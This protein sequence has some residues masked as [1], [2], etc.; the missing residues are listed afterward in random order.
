MLVVNSSGK[1][2]LG[3]RLGKPGHWQFPQGGV[4][5]GESLRKN[6]LR[7]LREEIGIRRKHIASIKKLAAKNW[8]LWK[9]VPAY[10]KGRW[11]GQT[12]TFWLIEFVGSDQ[13]IDLQ[14]SAEPEFKRWRWC[15]LSQVRKLAA[16]ERIKGY[17]AALSEVAV[18]RR[19]A[20]DKGRGS[21]R[22]TVK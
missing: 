1:L 13:D 21:H 16:R 6:V 18:L 14:G 3:E 5:P 4:E 12:Q 9:K 2:F 10:A 17:E 15:S 11:I 7:E 19:Q 8:Y 20:N 22:K